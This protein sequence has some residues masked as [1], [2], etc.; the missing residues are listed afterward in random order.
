MSDIIRFQGWDPEKRD[1]R[2]IAPVDWR[3]MRETQR[4]RHLAISRVDIGS[5]MLDHAQG[6]LDRA[7]K[8]LEGRRADAFDMTLISAFTYGAAELIQRYLGQ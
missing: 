4:E 3:T 5:D 2:P 6:G 8:R 7:R 1:A